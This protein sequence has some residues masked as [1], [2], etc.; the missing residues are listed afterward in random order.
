MT[1]SKTGFELRRLDEGQPAGLI[2]DQGQMKARQ[3]AVEGMTVKLRGAL[4]RGR[5]PRNL[6]SGFLTRQQCGG[7]FRCLAGREYGCASHRDGGDA[8]CSNGI[9]VRIDLAERRLLDKVTEEM[10]QASRNCCT[11]SR[12][13]PHGP[14]VSVPCMPR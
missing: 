3:Q 14:T 1:F 6:L 7:A 8:S 12:V 5:L 11:G 9:R 13:L 2:G 4:K 10:L